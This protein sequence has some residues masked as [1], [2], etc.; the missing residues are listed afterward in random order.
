M[1]KNVGTADKIVRVIIAIVLAVLYF[2]GIVKGVLGIIFL[3][4]AI[5][6]ILTSIFSFCLLYTLFGISTCP[7]KTQD[8][9]EEK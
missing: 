1:K 3:I 6:L 4:L 8:S 7:T 2:A 9:S 5:I